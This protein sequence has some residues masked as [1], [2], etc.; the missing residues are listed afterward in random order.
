MK[1]VWEGACEEPMRRCTS[2]HFPASQATIQQPLPFPS[3][4]AAGEGLTRELKPVTVTSKMRAMSSTLW[5]ALALVRGGDGRLRGKGGRGGGNAAR[6]QSAT[7]P[8]PPCKSAN[9][10]PACVGAR[11]AS[12]S[13]LAQRSPSRATRPI[14]CCDQGAGGKAELA[15]RN[16]T[17]SLLG[18]C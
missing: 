13:L 14:H 8:S 15:A 7:A 4:H 10:L 17:Q 11:L 5:P 1:P 12:F 18:R 6:Q 9:P 2:Q 16:S 3:F